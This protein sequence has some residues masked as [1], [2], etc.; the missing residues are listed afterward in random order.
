MVIP[1]KLRIHRAVL[2]CFLGHSGD[3]RCR[4]ILL[5][6]SLLSTAAYPCFLWIDSDVSDLSGRSVASGQDLTVEDDSSAD[7]GPQ[8]HHNNTLKATSASAPLLTQSCDIGIVAHTDPGDT[9]HS[10]K[11]LA[12]GENTPSQIGTLEHTSVLCDRSRYTHTD[13]DNIFDRDLL[14]LI[15]IVDRLCDIRKNIR[16]GFFLS[17]RDLPLFQKFLSLPV[18]QSHLNGRSPKVYAINILHFCFRLSF[19]F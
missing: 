7:S 9:G 12:D 10:A 5:E 19:Y 1:A 8:C 18:K 11:L 4:R 3:P 13:S 16:S 17:R 2:Q 14:F 6:T 15:F